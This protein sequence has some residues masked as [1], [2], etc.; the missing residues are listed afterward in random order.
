MKIMRAFMIGLLFLLAVLVLVGMGFLLSPV[1]FVLAL[2]F[3]VILGFI[4]VLF[5]IWLLGRFILFIWEKLNS[6]DDPP[7]DQP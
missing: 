5:G 4:L 2:I 1:F 7:K 3:R 6:S